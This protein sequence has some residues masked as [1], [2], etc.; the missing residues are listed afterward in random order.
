VKFIRLASIAAAT[1]LPLAAFAAG[2]ATFSPDRFKAHV[3]YLSDDL[4]EG[5]ETGTRGY[6]LAAKYVAAQMALLGLQPG[7]ENG[8]FFQQVPFVESAN[9]GAPA[10][11][12]ITGPDGTKTLTTADGVIVRGQPSGGDV[13]VKAGA[14]F[15]GYGATDPVSNTDDYKGLDVA[16]KAVVLVRGVPPGLDSEV[17]A[18]MRAQQVRNAAM[19]GAVAVI[20]MP[21]RAA[22][23][24]ASPQ[25]TAAEA[26]RPSTTWKGKDGVVGGTGNLVKASASLSNDAATLMFA[27]AEKTLVQVQ[28]EFAA[29]KRPAGFALKT[30]VEMKATTKA[31]TFTS[32]EVIGLIPGS[33]PKL[34]DEYV[35]LMAHLDHLGMRT[36]G[37]GDRIYNGALDNAAGVATLLE[38]AHAFSNSSQRPK[39]SILVIANAGEEKGLLG[40]DYYAH[41]PTVPAGKIVAAIDMDMPVLTY[42]FKDVVAYG[43]SH[44]TL[45][46]SIARAASAMGVKLAPDFQPDQAVF[47]RSDHY[48]LARVGV[49]AVMLATGPGNG[50]AEAWKKFLN[51]Q[52]HRPSDDM[53]Q[54]IHWDD[55]ARFA[56]LNYRVVRTLADARERPLWYEQDY[57]GDR[58]PNGK[59][60]HLSPGWIFP[61]GYSAMSQVRGLRVRLTET[62]DTRARTRS[63]PAHRR[64]RDRPRARQHR[65]RA[66][67]S[68]HHPVRQ[69]RL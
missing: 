65:G 28:E 35:V 24:Q 33:D 9:T 12:T 56:E 22:A 21:T 50:G 60:R 63:A 46:K 17:G 47:V 20:Y 16:G 38:V 11:L 26:S 27:G 42:S 59:F 45:E 13:D 34:K 54:D 64:Y 23:R 14:V 48:A 66:G 2:P 29:S 32:P 43:G 4:M 15:V 51:T 57:F 37:E 69:R 8:T 40:A 10:I 25:N 31:R 5:R 58:R 52:Y 6:E 61:V 18:H 41:Y 1:A 36:T 67:A 30:T 7:G 3:A 55:G 49:P 53:S 39:R 68:G 19:H 44:S 62:H